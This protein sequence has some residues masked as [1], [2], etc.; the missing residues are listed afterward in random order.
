MINNILSLLIWL[1]IISGLF[2]LFYKKDDSFLNIFNI[3]INLIVFILSILLLNNYD[4]T[5]QIFNLLKI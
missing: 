1:P 5:H 2:I 4:Q 3:S